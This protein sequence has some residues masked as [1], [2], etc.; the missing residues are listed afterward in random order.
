MWREFLIREIMLCSNIIYTNLLI[1]RTCMI[2]LAAVPPQIYLVL[3]GKYSIQTVYIY[4]S[5]LDSTRIVNL[6]KLVYVYLKMLF[7]YF[8]LFSQGY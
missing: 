1:C 3:V 7:P 6:W 8:A 4:I 2:P 5:I